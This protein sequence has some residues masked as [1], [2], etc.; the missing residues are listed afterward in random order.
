MEHTRNSEAVA[1]RND[2]RPASARRWLGLA[3][4]SLL[5]AGFFSLF[6]VVG[7]APFLSGFFDDP[8]FFRRCL[9]VHVNLALVV[10]FYAFLAGLVSLLPG[11]PRRSPMPVLLSGAGVLLLVIAGGIPDAV[12]VLSNYVPMIDHPVFAAGLL[13]IAAGIGEAMIRVLVD[14]RGEPV[15]PFAP[16][17]Q[18]GLKA[19][20]VAFLLA[21]LTVFGAWVGTPSDTITDLYFELLF[22]GGGHVLQFSSVA[23]MVAIW[24]HLVA[25]G[26][27]QAV[28]SPRIAR[29]LFG[30]LLLPLPFAPVI[31]LA[32][33]DGA[34][35]RIGATRLMQWGIFPVVSTFIVLAVLA[36][37]RHARTIGTRAVLTDA[38]IAG[39]AA[40]AALTIVGF[41]LGAMIR[42]SNTMVPAHYHAAIGAVTVAFMAGAFV[43]L[44][45]LG[46]PLRSR[47]Q[48]RLAAWQPA[49]FGFGQLVFAIGFGIAGAN[50]M[51]RKVYGQEQ[52]IDSVVDV[53]GLALMGVGGLMAMAGGLLFIGL[54]AAAWRARRGASH[55]ANAGRYT[56][57]N[58]PN[59][60]RTQKIAS[61][62]SRS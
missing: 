10:W 14:R 27:G 42:G 44:P 5:L 4:A 52:H 32:G 39:F 16:E 37:V 11:G 7:R 9:V 31:A 62:Q 46:F 51:G 3:L 15:I 58:I 49:L 55:S 59:I 45:A 2:E 29:F 21:V 61:T 38:G 40:S 60:P 6:L 28:V 43:L 47:L 25:T 22:W 30:L 18:L 33:T 19:A 26:T 13:L 20:A 12:P 56:W 50:G 34:L 23:A 53:L 54:I 36:I 57:R 48:Q 41:I 35:Y 24:L 1:E 17:A 8:H